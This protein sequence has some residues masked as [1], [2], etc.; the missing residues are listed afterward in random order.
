MEKNLLKESFG[1]RTFDEED[2]LIE[3]V[4]NI[5]WVSHIILWENDI[6]AKEEAIFQ[7]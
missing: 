1:N 6:I 4:P 3:I 5:N 7:G 2:P